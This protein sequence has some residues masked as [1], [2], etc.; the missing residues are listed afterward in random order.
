MHPTL[1]VPINAILLVLVTNMGL[2]SI[3]FGTVEGF[4]TVL[5][6]CTEAFCKRLEDHD[7]SVAYHTTDLSYIMPLMAR[8]WQHLQGHHK[9]DSAYSLGKFGMA[10]NVVGLIYLLFAIITVC[11]PT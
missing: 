4:N 8:I 7:A 6:I 10:I 1:H 11:A 5:A 3:Y 9:I 2:M